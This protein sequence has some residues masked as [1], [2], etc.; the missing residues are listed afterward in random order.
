[1]LEGLFQDRKVR[2]EINESLQNALYDDVQT[3]ECDVCHTL[4]KRTYSVDGH[5]VCNRCID[6]IKFVNND[7]DVLLNSKAEVWDRVKTDVCMTNEGYIIPNIEKLYDTANKSYGGDIKK[8]LK[9]YDIKFS[10]SDLTSRLYRGELYIGKKFISTP[11]KLNRFIDDFDCKFIRASGYTPIVPDVDGYTATYDIVKPNDSFYKD[12]LNYIQ[13]HAHDVYKDIKNPV[14][15][16]TDDRGYYDTVEQLATSNTT[17]T[18]IQKSSVTQT[19]KSGTTIG[20]GANTSSSKTKTISASGTDKD[21]EIKLGTKGF[22]LHYVKNTNQSKLN[23]SIVEYRC[24]FKYKNKVISAIDVDIVCDIN[25]YDS[26]TKSAFGCTKLYELLP[27][28]DDNVD[29]VVEVD[30]DGIITHLELDVANVQKK[31]FIFKVLDHTKL[32]DDDTI[33]VTDAD[34]LMSYGKF[35]SYVSKYILME[36]SH[37]YGVFVNAKKHTVSSSFGDI[38]WYMHDI[39]DKGELVIEIGC[40]GNTQDVVVPKSSEYMKDIDEAVRSLV[41]DNLV[42]LTKF[43]ANVLSKGITIDAYGF[44]VHYSIYSKDT[45]KVDGSLDM[46]ATIIDG[47]GNEVG[48]D[49]YVISDTRDIKRSLEDYTGDMLVAKELIV[50]D[51]N[52]QIMVWSK[53]SDSKTRV[54]VLYNQIENNFKD[55]YTKLDDRL[56]IRV[57]KLVVS[58]NG[59]INSCTFSIVDDENVYVDLDTMVKDLSLKIDSAYAVV[60]KSDTGYTKYVQYEAFDVDSVEQFGIDIQVKLLENAFRLMGTAINESS[61][62]EGK[63]IDA[64]NNKYTRVINKIRSKDNKDADEGTDVG[65]VSTPTG[66]IPSTDGRG[67]GSLDTNKKEISAF[68]MNDVVVE[69]VISEVAFKLTTK[70]GK[71]VKVRMTPQEEKEAKEKRQAYYDK[72]AKEAGDKVRSSKVAKQNKKLGHDLAKKAED[73]AVVKAKKTLAKRSKAIDRKNSLKKMRENR[74]SKY[75]ELHSKL[76]DLRKKREGR[77]KSITR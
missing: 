26:I 59:M 72:K 65:G 5:I 74:E 46:F 50:L 29:Y 68:D 34:M 6:F 54:K 23:R 70:N 69:E 58:P 8:L 33:T 39:T 64:V 15:R 47:T 67:V 19:P 56:D 53:Y 63:P 11:S 73:K 1:M 21:F 35:N 43:D 24:E 25:D 62:N 44:K 48:T 66:S 77:P 41:Y 9:G 20:S 36:L 71:R 31:G 28:M 42:T 22:V 38:E 49:K 51:T 40:C 10:Q 37:N 18:K 12:N 55:T 16:N 52:A 7:F 60:D 13:S 14:I 76:S 57:D 61:S 3:K 27:F 2:S 75:R 4:A 32:F 45:F 17:A 30:T